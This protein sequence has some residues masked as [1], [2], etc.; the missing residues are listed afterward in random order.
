MFLLVKLIELINEKIICYGFLLVV[1]L[2]VII[3][4][5]V[6]FVVIFLVMFNLG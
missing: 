2:I 1:N 4:I 3:L 5:I 6:I